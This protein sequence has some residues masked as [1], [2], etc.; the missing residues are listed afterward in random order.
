MYLVKLL[1]LIA[2]LLLG[3]CAKNPVTGDSVFALITED[4]EISQGRSYHPEIIK[5]Y[6]VYDDPELQQYVN[7]I[8]QQLAAKSHR[9]QLEFN[10]T[11]L[12]SPEINAFALPGGYVYIT[13]GIMAYLDS[14]AELAGVL[15]HEIGHVTARHSV[16]Q[17]AGQFATGLLNVLITATTGQSA[18]GTLSQQLSTGLVRGYGREH[19]LEADRLGAEYLHKIGYDPETM[20]D[21]ISVLKNQ[22]VYETALA[23]RENRPPNTYHGVYSTH[24]ENDD[25][26]QT[27][28]RSAKKLSV[29]KYRDDN[30][31][32]Y[33]GRIDGLVWGSSLEQGVVVNN[34]FAHP[35][36][37]IAVELPD[38][39]KV[40]NNPQFLEARD[41]AT[42][43]LLQIGVVTALE[44]E[45]AA[46]ALERLGNTSEL[47]VE[48]TAYGATAT[49]ST[50]AHDG[51]SQPARITAI[52][53]QDDLMLILMG[54]SQAKHFTA[55]D[56]KFL[57][58][59]ASFRHLDPAQVAAIRAPRL[60]IIPRSAQ[61][62][63]SLAQQS[64]LEYEAINIL[65]LLNRSFPKGDINSLT[66]IKTVSLED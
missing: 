60:H 25:R 34:T 53:L 22:E 66:Q 24:P 11:V 37:A 39:W 5:T 44:D 9:S 41:P 33:L 51:K 14:E 17:Q 54:I 48:T 19:E 18:L 1:L 47:K 45:S 32:T 2:S 3:A 61:S 27:V 26:L 8:G 20:L 59:N 35:G 13:R 10:F 38:G 21:V 36:L 58:T 62:F 12:D 16:R 6:G 52:P 23:K 42:S 49:G 43:A 30:Q 55:T 50:S 4:E 31:Q 28:V 56:R 65:R 64:A 15:G 57:A 7:R 46:D 63:K 40:D 29:K